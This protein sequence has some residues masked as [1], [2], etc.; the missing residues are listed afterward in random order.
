[1]ISGLTCQ[2]GSKTETL[3]FSTKAMMAVEDA[4]GAGIVDVLAA[5]EDQFTIGQIVRIFAACGNDGQGRPIEWAQDAVDTI[6]VTEAVK[7]I[8]DCATKAFP[9]AAGDEKNAKGPC[10]K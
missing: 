5:M 4:E 7:H 10:R 9:E 8:G 6:G 2:I 1:M 3:R